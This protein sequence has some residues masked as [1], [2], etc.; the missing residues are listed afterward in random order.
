MN[1]FQMTDEQRAIRKQQNY[2]RYAPDRAM[3]A[4]FFEQVK[5]H[6]VT[7]SMENGIYRHVTLRKPGTSHMHFNLITFPGYLCYT[8]DMGT[9]VFQRLD[10][11]FEFFREK[12]DHH[13]VELGLKLYT[14]HSYWSEKLC[15]SDCSGRNE[16]KSTEFDPVRFKARII[17][18]LREWIKDSREEGTLDK[19]ER[20]ELWEAV[21]D[22]VIDK[23]DDYGENAQ[24]LAY[25]FS[26]SPFQ[27]FGQDARESFYFQDLFESNFQQY[28]HSFK[29]ACLAIAWGIQQ[30]DAFKDEQAKKTA[31]STAFDSFPDDFEVN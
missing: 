6:K 16:G 12:S 8:G 29:W 3:E 20:R 19:E 24:T 25:E 23:V 18:D 31:K 10:D 9:F 4:E 1:P 22:Q 30:Y 5:D 28:T 14:N 17:E 2:D 13:L 21:H 15:A 26:W 7:V 27:K 11:M